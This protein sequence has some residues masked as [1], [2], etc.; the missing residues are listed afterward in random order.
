MIRGADAT[1][2]PLLLCLENPRHGVG[3][4]GPVL[5]LFDELALAV[6]REPVVLGLTVVLRRVPFRIDPAL[7]LQAMER[8]VERPLVD[9]Q[10]V[11]RDLLDALRDAP[12]VHRLERQRLQDEHVERAL[13]EILFL[14]SHARRLWGRDLSNVNRRGAV[15]D[16]LV[17]TI[18]KSGRML[19]ASCRV[20]TST[21]L[22][23]RL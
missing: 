5:A 4:P 19:R 12:A 22:G 14:T 18:D 2:S 3:H 21:A 7:L 9:P 13:Q 17:L 16:P 20:S 23:S 1:A 6:A 10:D 11:A 8:R 15:A